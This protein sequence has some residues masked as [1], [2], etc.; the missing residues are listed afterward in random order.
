MSS[1][2]RQAIVDLFDRFSAAWNAND[3]TALG[4][5]Y[6]EDGCLIDPFGRRADGRAAIADAFAGLFGGP[7]A[8]T[9][10]LFAIDHVRTV[11]SMHALVDGEQRV[12]A[13]DGS[14]VL[15]VHIAS[16]V[17]REN[18]GW[19]VVD[20]RPYVIAPLPGSAPAPG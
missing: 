16:L 8:G 10:T 13:P 11:E 5:C 1:P 20:G 3:A 9:S 15:A 14:V 19:K 17:R 12:V 18:D 6:S 4:R 7:M 2:C